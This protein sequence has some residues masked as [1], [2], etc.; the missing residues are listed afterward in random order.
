M[1][2]TLSSDIAAAFASAASN[3]ALAGAIGPDSHVLGGALLA[4]PEAD[5]RLADLVR[6]YQE[7]DRQTWAP[8]LLEAMAPALIPWLARVNGEPPYLSREDVAQQLVVE[9]LS[10]ALELDLNRDSQHIARRLLRKA[11]HRVAEQLR[12]EA[13]NRRH[14]VP[15]EESV[16][17]GA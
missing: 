12:Q 6:R 16:D 8:A 14:L 15:F 4:T 1:A 17:D 9:L 11:A 3:P 5:R 10:K 7:S 2:L 13:A